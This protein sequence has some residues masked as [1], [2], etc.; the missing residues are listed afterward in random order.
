DSA[1]DF[2]WVAAYVDCA[3]LYAYRW[4]SGLNSG[5][6]ADASRYGWIPKYRGTC[7]IRCD[8]F[9]QFQPFPGQIV[10]KQHKAGGIAARTRQ[11]NN[12]AGATWIRDASNHT[13]HSAGQL[14]QPL[15]GGATTGENNIWREGDQF[16]RYS[17]NS[18]S[19]APAP[20]I[21]DP[22]VTSV[23][24]TQFLQPL[25]KR[26]VACPGIRIISHARQHADA[27][28]LIGLRPRRQRPSYCSPAEKPDQ[29]PSAHGFAPAEH[30]SKTGSIRSLHQQLPACFVGT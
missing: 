8:L 26:R 17:A 3:N 29:F 13:R 7:H 27:P 16:R 12:E 10:F 9:Q 23:Y 5:E 20:T 19:I 21:V 22:Y 24:P 30:R 4:C 2:G 14:K 1:L 11:T 25:R 15:C 18:V 28:H 6:L